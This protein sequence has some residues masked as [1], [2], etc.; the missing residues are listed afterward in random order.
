MR[1]SRAERARVVDWWLTADRTLL[2]LI[3]TLAAA[4]LAA[5]VI[6]T[7]ST[8]YHLKGYPFYFAERHAVGMAAG[9]LAMFAVSLLSPAGIKRFALVL[10]VCGLALMILVLLQGVERNGATRWLILAG[11]RVQPSEFAKPGFV[12]LSAWA[13]A[14]SVKRPDMP[15]LRACAVHACG[16]HRAARA[17]AGYGASDYRCHR[18]VRPPVPRR[19]FAAAPALGCHPWPRSAWRWPISPCR[20]LPR[21]SICS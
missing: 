17:A 14:E 21:A 19:L 18:L 12:V 5:S 10:F 4:G 2:A 1:F 8:A 20:I 11:T 15:A 16:L 7:P 13:F 9:M 3:L 6:A